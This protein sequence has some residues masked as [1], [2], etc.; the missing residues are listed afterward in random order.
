[1]AKEKLEELE[2]DVE[3]EETEQSEESNSAASTDFKSVVIKECERIIDQYIEICKSNNDEAFLKALDNP[4]KTKDNCVN[5]IMNNLTKKRIYGGADSVMYEYIHEYYVDDFKEVKDNWSTFMRTP[6]SG[7]STK[8]VDEAAIR[9][10]AFKEAKKQFEAEHGKIDVE[11]I[12]KKAIADYKAEEKA[13]KEEQARLKEEAKAKAEAEKE[14]KRKAME[15]AKKKEEEEAN[16]NLGGL[17][18]L[19]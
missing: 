4:D 8:K 6:S 1:M 17:F 18:D 5:H 14:A 2:E 10:K 12:R 15:E 13:K 3:E 7:G 16:Q 11:A 19:L 9:D